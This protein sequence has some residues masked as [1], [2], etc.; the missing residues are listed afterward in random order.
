LNTLRKYGRS[1]LLLLFL[2]AGTAASG[3][4]LPPDLIPARQAPL[5]TDDFSSDSLKEAVKINLAY[6]ACQPPGKT[7]QIAGQTVSHTRLVRSLQLF[8]DILAQ[9]PSPAELD[10]LIKEQ[11]EIIQAA[12]TKEGRPGRDLLVTGYFQPIFSGSLTREAPFLYPLYGVPGD[13]VQQGNASNK[14]P[15]FGR[16]EKGQLVPYWTR[17]EIE[18]Q[19]RAAG[20]EL[21]WLKDPF[22]A[23]LVHI[24]GSAIIQFRDGSRRGIHFAAKNGHPYR[25]IGSHLIRTGRLTRQKTTMQTIRDY[26]ADHPSERDEILHSNPSF[27]FFEWTDTT[28]VI[29]SLGTKLTAGRSMAADHNVFP[30][31]TLGFLVSRQPKV[32]EDNS[33]RWAPL[34]R[35]V[36]VQDSGSAIK[37]SGRLDLFWGTGPR[38]GS[39]A[40]LMRENG[41]L[42]FFLA[43]EQPLPSSPDQAGT[44]PGK[45]S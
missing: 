45:G 23:Y 12:G 32:A 40:G 5:F 22:E 6:L 19:Q 14:G 20:H 9:K 38:A 33:V 28:A 34:H 7:V 35:F 43:R 26:I 42:Y 10:R 31:G 39:E 41:A 25:S 11:F 4:G 27:I 3:D 29:G 36:L 1:L 15:A 13:L 18:K 24:Q 8:Q 30:P 2:L 17:A 37:G 21:V 44:A 16:L